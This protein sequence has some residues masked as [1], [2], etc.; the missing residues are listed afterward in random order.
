MCC[1]AVCNFISDVFCRCH[2]LLATCSVTV[3]HISLAI[4]SVG[5]CHISLAMC[6]ILYRI[7]LATC[8]VG[9]NLISL[10][11][12]SV[13]MCSEAVYNILLVMCS[14][15][16]DIFCRCASHFITNCYVARCEVDTSDLTKQIQQT[17]IFLL[18]KSETVPVT[19][20]GGL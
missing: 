1:V 10:A 18:K 7:S 6:S 17:Y 3:C 2:I 15:V 5:V 8:S 9:V 11:T 14:V 16:S 20:C 12:C 4:C 13:A 19:G